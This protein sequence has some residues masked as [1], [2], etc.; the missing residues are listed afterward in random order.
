MKLFLLSY[1]LAFSPLILAQSQATT[2]IIEGTVTDDSGNPLPG[3]TVSITNTANNYL[4]VRVTNAEGRYRGGLLP[5]GPYRVSVTMEGFA[6][7]VRD[8]LRLT[9]GRTL[10]VNFS[11]KP[12][13]VAEEIVVKA[14][15][16]VVETS[17]TENITQIDEMAV[18]GLPNNGRNFL[19]F[20]TLSAGVTIVQGPDGEEISVNGQK[21]INNNISLDGTDFNN[22][23]FGEQ[24]GGQ[25]AAFT[26]N[27]DAVEEV[28][29]VS[30]GA[31]AEFG[32]SSSGFVNV[33]TK[34]GTNNMDGSA[35]YFLRNDS[36]NGKA[37]NPNGSRAEKFDYKS[38]QAGFTIGGPIV[39]DKIFYFLTYDN[40]GSDSTKQTDPTRIEQ[41]VLDYF[42]SVGYPNEN[43]PITRTDD[44]WAFSLKT[45]FQL[46]PDH[47]LT[48]RFSATD[49]EQDN[50]TFDVDSWGAS[51]NATELGDSWSFSGAWN[52]LWGNGI[53]NELRFQWARENRPRAYNSNN[54]TGQ[55]RPLPDTAF[56]FGSSYRFGMPFF[57]PV[58]YH[59]TRV[60]I[61]ENISWST[62]NHFFKAG[63]EVN[64]TRA[65]QTFVGFANGRFIF[66]STEGFLNYTAN[67]NYIECG[68]ADGDYVTSSDD[69]TCP[70]GTTPIGP[71]LL[72]LQQAGV[73]GLT[74]EEAGTQLQETLEAA[75]FFQDAWQPRD[76]LTVNY[77]IR[78]E[79]QDHPE[80]QTPPEQ[81]FFAP[82]IG[83]T[84]ASGQIFPS[85]GTIPDD[86][87]MWQPRLAITWDPGKDGKSLLRMTGGVYYSR[88]PGLMLASVRSTNGSIGQNIFRS[89]DTGFLGPTPA[90]LDLVEPGDGDPG[91][92][93]VFVASKNFQNPRTDAFSLT[94]ERELAPS[95]AASVKFVY[96]KGS[97][98]TRYINR[99]DPQ[100][101]T[102]VP[103]TDPDQPSTYIPPW[104]SGLSEGGWNGISALTTMES[105]GESI[106]RGY[107]FS[108]NKAMSN[109]YT[110]QFNYTYSK[111]RSHDDNERDPFTFRYANINHLDDE[112]GYSDRDQRHRLNGWILWN[113]PGDVQINT[114]YTYRSAQPKSLKADGTDANEPADRYDPV[115]DTVSPRNTG[116]KNNEFRSL[117][118]RISKVFRFEGW[119]LEPIIEGFNLTNSR[120]LLNPS[121]TNLVFNFDGTVQ[122]GAGQPRQ[123]Q[124]GM[125]GR[126]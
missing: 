5:L 113:A 70:A 29:V 32:R 115:T 67:P 12:S 17:R 64:K 25:R 73:G 36:L 121:V 24:R 109:R 87:D 98:Q 10:V 88:I 72:Y 41:S 46:N 122:S 62:A 90:Y 14:G 56:D 112:W 99:N 16:D 9:V 85:D 124:L 40:Q 8:S 84:S 103:S 74:S 96:A 81:V 31:P 111:D 39:K 68:N 37:E 77:G 13:Q 22:P 63:V 80:V 86:K 20:M 60:Q 27:L 69:G 4:Q 94:Y 123:I 92:P 19:D 102:L 2:G 78:W 126:W 118:I 50:G 66:S 76:N 105:T 44:A 101:G 34:S 52:S 30:E 110:F 119:E 108:L 65:F 1:L 21:G 3:A 120:N 125:K 106:Y 38:Q 95:L 58:Q 28:V 116:R 42:A 91:F 35:H 82:Y 107:T 93:D 15:T 43:A 53:Y 45:D 61:N 114:R 75:F 48:L 100:L 26:F 57:I 117:D 7:G 104:S 97:H 51:A 89:S 71:V 54:I 83:T 55:D 18:Q 79:M 11:L 47:R 59:D 23:F 6:T 49:S 33:I